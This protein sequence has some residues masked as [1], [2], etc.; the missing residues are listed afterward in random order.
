M[1]MTLTWL[2]QGGFLLSIGGASVCIDPYLSDNCERHGGHTRIA[3]PPMDPGKLDADVIVITHDHMDHLDELTLSRLDVSENLFAAPFLCRKHLMEIGVPEDR[4]LSFDRG[5]VFGI[6]DAELRAVYA[7]HTE[8][9]IGVLVKSGHHSILFTGDS[10]Y[11]EKLVEELKNIH[12]DVFVVCVNGRWGNMNEK[13]AARL[14]HEIGA[15]LSIP[16]HYG[17]FAENTADPD[18]FVRAMNGENVKL[19]KMYEPVEL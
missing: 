1:A 11:S 5:D 16:T 9:S 7:D 10:L 18:D 15:K 17:M 12:P 8:D 6:M 4:L 2:G 13:E 3:P 14:S 19:L